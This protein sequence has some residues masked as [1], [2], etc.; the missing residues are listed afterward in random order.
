MHSIR[1]DHVP[2][3]IEHLWRIAENANADRAQWLEKAA[4]ETNPEVRAGWEQLAKTELDVARTAQADADDL[5]ARFRAAGG[6][7]HPKN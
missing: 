3:M 4:R 2:A 1:L 6:E 7:M 5:L